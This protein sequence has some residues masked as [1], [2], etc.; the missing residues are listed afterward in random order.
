VKF[1]I[2]FYELNKNE[3]PV[4]KFLED[5]K[6]KNPLLWKKSLAGILKIKERE[7][8]RMPLTESIGAGIFSLRIKSENNM[9]EYVLVS[10]DKIILLHGC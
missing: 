6:N 4:E 9:C 7:Y 10:K 2:E 8:Q 3:R 5:L 1:E